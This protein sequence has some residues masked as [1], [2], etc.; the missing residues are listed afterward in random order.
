MCLVTSL[1]YITVYYWASHLTDSPVFTSGSDVRASH[2]SQ[3]CMVST[4]KIAD[5]QDHCISV[6]RLIYIYVLS[7]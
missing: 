3:Y 7:N 6:L 4:D 2:P 1:G 5:I